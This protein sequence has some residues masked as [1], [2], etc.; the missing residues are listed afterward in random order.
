MKIAY[1]MQV[2]KNFNQIKLLTDRL[3]DELTCVYIHVDKKNEELFKELKNE[4][5]NNENVFIIDNRVEVNWSGFSQV[6]AT[7]NLMESALKNNKFKFEYISLISGQDFPIKNNNYIRKFLT[8]NNGFE[9][10]QYR[11]INNDNEFLFRLKIYNFFR[12]NKNARK[13]YV[14]I[15]DNILRRLQKLVIKRNNLEGLDL[16]TGSSWFT[17]SRECVEY[18][19][20]HLGENGKYILDFKYTFCPDEEFF[21]ILILNSKFK[22]KVINDNLRYIDWE[23]CHGSPRTLGISDI[24]K[25]KS[26]NKHL[27][28]KIDIDIDS[29]IIPQLILYIEEDNIYIKQKI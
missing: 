29:E 3:V 11:N 13:I 21:Q 23:G 14:K 28:R 2:H 7:L 5:T 4:Y 25:I 26:S 20:K 8:D 15:V 9:F 24:N 16:Y 27:A 6:Q 18:I 1:I 10:I 22:E 19:F 12:E 17:L